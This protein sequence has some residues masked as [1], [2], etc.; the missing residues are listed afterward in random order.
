M[1]GGG[2]GWVMEVLLLWLICC[3][4]AARLSGRRSGS[5][6]V[7]ASLAT[8]STILFSGIPTCAGHHTKVA[9]KVSEVFRRVCIA[10]RAARRSASAGEVVKRPDKA[11]INAWLSIK[12]QEL[13]W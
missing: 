2:G 5:P 10:W 4:R 13:R 7:V 11:F 9:E 6:V 8:S 12:N 1:M 3:R